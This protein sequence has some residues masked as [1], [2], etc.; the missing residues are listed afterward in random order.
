MQTFSG[1][2]G[3]VMG[4]GFSPDGQRIA[5]ASADG[6]ARI[7]DTTTGKELAAM[8]C[9]DQGKEWAVVAPDGTYDGSPTG[10]QALTFREAGT[11]KLTAP[12]K[13][14]HKPGLL[15][16]IWGGKK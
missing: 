4:V 3:A 16:E 15:A 2:L 5:T 12:T 8:L 13:E 6:T 9:V 7:W 11:V 1:H 14:Q 10:L